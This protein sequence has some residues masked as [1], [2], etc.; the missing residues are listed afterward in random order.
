MLRG[1]TR[2]I[3]Y[4]N[5]VNLLEVMYRRSR[6]SPTS[7]DML[8]ASFNDCQKAS[9]KIESVDMGDLIEFNFKNEPNF[10][11]VTWSSV[12]GAFDV[13]DVQG[14]AF[15]V[16]A[17]S[18]T[19]ILKRT[20]NSTSSIPQS[21]AAVSRGLVQLISNSFSQCRRFAPYLDAAY[22]EMSLD[23]RTRAIDFE[24]LCV[25]VLKLMKSHESHARSS[26]RLAIYFLVSFYDVNFFRLRNGPLLIVSTRIS[27]C[28]NRV[29]KSIGPGDLESLA[30]NLGEKIKN[31]DYQLAAAAKVVV[32]FLKHYVVSQDSRLSPVVQEVISYLLPTHSE[33]IVSPIAVKDYLVDAGLMCG[34]P[35]LDPELIG[36]NELEDY[37][38]LGESEVA[39]VAVPFP[40][41]VY[42]I[43][44]DFAISIDESRFGNKQVLAFHFPFVPLKSVI[45]FSSSIA[46]RGKSLFSDLLHRPLLDEN[47]REK[48]RLTPGKE[49]VCISISAD[50]TDWADSLRPKKLKLSLSSCKIVSTDGR[51]FFEA[52][53]SRSSQDV[54]LSD[55]RIDKLRLVIDTLLSNCNSNELPDFDLNYADRNDKH[56][57]LR[58]LAGHWLALFAQ[59]WNLDFPFLYKGALKS[60]PA[61]NEPGTVDIE[62][63]R[64][65]PGEYASLGLPSYVPIAFPFDSSV[66]LTTQQVV[67]E[68][69]KG[70]SIYRNE[71]VA[72]VYNRNMLPG[73]DLANVIFE[74]VE[75]YRKLEKIRH[76]SLNGSRSFFRCIM[77]EDG[78]PGEGAAAYCIDESCFVNVIVDAKL[79][80]GDRIICGS[81][82]A[83]DPLRGILLMRI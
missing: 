32:S 59:E 22:A 56:N 7:R 29:R 9:F 16:Q 37:A 43:A 41:A 54:P 20:P 60:F 2:S 81:I 4:D 13:V 35:F 18:V 76:S 69:V 67:W 83:V 19:F 50:L 48:F 26:D 8:P 61:V 51:S 1:F 21:P 68:Y 12:G 57:A 15:T 45:S 23:T 77:L 72:D 47:V 3:S 78:T 58:V 70:D 5:S 36:G 64:S 63:V 10:G 71:K 24:H 6:P 44:D 65:K 38:Y 74:G 42:L 53:K 40:Q 52:N 73:A 79:F 46:I 30:Y 49:C 11:L 34:N 39:S 25:K 14:K 80:R 17:S 66:A 75:T 82:V 55:F 33:A 62:Q 31:K 27:D 28:L